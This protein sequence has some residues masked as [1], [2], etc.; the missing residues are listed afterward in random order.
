MKQT[1]FL[2]LQRR[3]W[4]VSRFSTRFIDLDCKRSRPRDDNKSTKDFLWQLG[5]VVAVWKTRVFNN[6]LARVPATPN[7]EETKEIRDEV[8]PSVGAQYMDTG[9]R[10]G[11]YHWEDPDMNMDSFFQP[12]VGTPFSPSIFNKFEMGSMT[13]NP[14]LTDIEQGK[15]NCLPP[16]PTT[17]VSDRPTQP[18]VLMKSRPWKY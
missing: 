13:E 9:A 7:Q 8:L 10:F 2:S 17:P 16:L 12:G 4:V 5:V 18:L 1:D 6:R 11:G 3:Y 15:E 14:I